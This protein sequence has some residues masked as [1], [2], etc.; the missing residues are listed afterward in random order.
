MIADPATVLKVTVTTA[1]SVKPKDFVVKLTTPVACGAVPPPPT[2]LK[3]KDAQDYIL[4]NGVKTD[5][6][7]MGDVLTETPAHIRKIAIEPAVT[8]VKLRSPRTPRMLTP[9]TS[10]ST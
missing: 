10:S 8:A 2:E 4:A 9:R 6:D 3:I 7:A 1:A 5:T